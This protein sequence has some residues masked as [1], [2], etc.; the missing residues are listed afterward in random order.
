MSTNVGYHRR[1]VTINLDE[2]SV[3][4]FQ[5]GPAGNIVLTRRV[6]RTVRH[7]ASRSL[8]RMS[9]TVIGVICDDVVIQKRLPQFVLANEA[10][11]AKRDL[12]E[13]QSVCHENVRLYRRRSAWTDAAF[14]LEVVTQ[15]WRSLEP[16]MSYI[17][18]ILIWDAARQHTRPHV[19]R[20]CA[21]RGIWPMVLP[22]GS[23]GL[24]QPLDTHCFN[25]F[26]RKLA[27]KCERSDATWSSLDFVRA[28]NGVF[29]DMMINGSWEHAFVS[30]GF[31][32]NQNGV[33][34][35]V[36]G[37]IG[38]LPPSIGNNRPTMEDL[39][40]VFPRRSRVDEHSVFAQF[41]IQLHRVARTLRP[42]IV[43]TREVMGRTRSETIALR[44]QM[45]AHVRQH[46]HVRARRRLCACVQVLS[47]RGD[48][49]NL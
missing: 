18:P 17:Q 36:V 4:L 16:L 49:G 24:L 5:P 30:N 3:P 12:A 23:T 48:D 22:A 38:A 28:V 43:P 31:S 26:K 29:V 46:V 9:V 47:E 19:L 10:T 42:T 33:S 41:S 2:S 7:H 39:T 37:A 20:C 21:R 34:E 40:L 27:F 25:A 6:A 1:A 14:M 8:R 11:F 15:L 35:R 32:N 45:S 44:A 13:L